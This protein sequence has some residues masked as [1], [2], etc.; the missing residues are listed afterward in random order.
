MGRVKKLIDILL[1][2][3]REPQAFGLDEDQRNLFALADAG[4]IARALQN[5]PDAGISVNK[6]WRMWD[7]NQPVLPDVINKLRV[8]LDNNHILR[9]VLAEHEM[10]L[11]FMSDLEDVNNEICELRSASSMTMEIRKLANIVGHL[12]ALSQ[13]RDRE[14]E[15]IFPQLRLC[16]YSAVLDVIKDQ[17][18]YLYHKREEL[19]K[20][21]WKIDTINF[22]QFKSRLDQIVGQLVPATRMHLF[23][24]SNIVCPLALEVISDSRIWSRMKDIADE[25][26][27]C[28][29]DAF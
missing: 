9:R 4:E 22:D 17:H 18:D 11:C 25:I 8:R 2:L 24:E 27:Y 1:G 7:K 14:E 12:I 26:G 23:I 15:I 19:R 5:L 21:L 13:H 29:S 10:T 16:G 20:L 6:L 28:S 3:V